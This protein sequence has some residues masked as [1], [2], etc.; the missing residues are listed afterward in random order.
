MENKKILIIE[1]EV[2]IEDILSYKLKKE[3]YNIKYCTTGTKGLEEIKTF[4]PNLV[5]LDL[6]L[7]DRSGF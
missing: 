3:G 7:P 2:S 5:L 1:D 6:M 4:M